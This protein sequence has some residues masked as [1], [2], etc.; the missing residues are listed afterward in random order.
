MTAPITAKYIEEE[1]SSDSSGTLFFTAQEPNIIYS[2]IIA[3]LN[4]IE[5]FIKFYDAK[6]NFYYTYAPVPAAPDDEAEY[7]PDFQSICHNFDHCYYISLQTAD[8]FL[9]E[10][11]EIFELSKDSFIHKSVKNGTL[12]ELFSSVDFDDDWDIAPT[13]H[14]KIYEV[15]VR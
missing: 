10:L 1:L 3:Y 2:A 8:P 7:E 11:D 15:T 5:P 12:K 13:E 4:E 14:Y 6:N 9:L